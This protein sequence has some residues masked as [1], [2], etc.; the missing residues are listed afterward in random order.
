MP[1]TSGR[2]GDCALELESGAAVSGSAAA[3]V[4]IG[5]LRTPVVVFASDAAGA[6]ARATSVKS[7]MSNALAAARRGWDAWRSARSRRPERGGTRHLQQRRCQQFS[8]FTSLQKNPQ[9]EMALLAL[10]QRNGCWDFSDGI[11]ARRARELLHG[12]APYSGSP[13]RGSRRST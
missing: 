12:V 4:F 7:D 5:V 6:V 2:S 1:A 13:R 11:Y 3:A 9:S 8:P 10:W